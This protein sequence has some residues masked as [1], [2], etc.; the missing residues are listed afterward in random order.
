VNRKHALIAL[1]VIAAVLSGCGSLGSTTAAGQ[2]S[3]GAGSP[4]APAAAAS[5]APCTTKAC[6]VTDAG[7]LKGTV[8]KDN[9][10]MTKVTCKK[11][12]VKQVVSGTYTV[13]CTATYSDGMVADGIASVLTAGTGSVDWEPTDIISDG[14]GG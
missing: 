10:V 13:H 12:T 5:S 1:A 4:S 2:P 14:S 7:G 11:S 3:G 9:S 8:A 6:I